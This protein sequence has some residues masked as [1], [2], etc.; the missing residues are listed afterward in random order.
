M[1]FTFLLMG[2]SA[3]VWATHGAALGEDLVYVKKD[4]RKE[5]REASIEATANFKLP[6]K[7]Q[8]LGPVELAKSSEVEPH[9]LGAA[10]PDLA[11]PAFAAPPV[12]WR[13]V[14][15]PDG[16]VHQ[17]GSL[18]P[19]KKAAVY[20]YRR[21]ETTEPRS[22]R[23]SLGYDDTMSVWLNGQL[24]LAAE[25]SRTTRTASGDMDFVTLPLTAGVNHLVM[26][27]ANQDG[28]WAFFCDVTIPTGPLVRL[29]RLLD[30]DFPPSGEA[31]YYRIETLPLPSGELI[32]VG[33]LAFRPDGAL[34]VATRRGDL[35]LVRNVEAEDVSEVQFQLFA[36]GLHESLG[37][38]AVNDHEVYVAQRPEITLVRDTNGDD[39]ADEYV[40]VSDRYNISGA[41]HEFVYGA[42]RN[43]AGDLFAGLNLSLSGDEPNVAYRGCILKIGQDGATAPI[44]FG[45]RSPNG[46][47]I[48]PQGKLFVT[49]NQGEWIP[50]CKMAAIDEGKFYGHKKSIRWVPGKKDDDEVEVA[51]PA[52]WFPYGLCRSATEPIWDTTAGK[53]GPFAG[54][55]FVGELT[56]SLILRTMLEEVNGQTQGACVAF[57]KGFASG[58]NR[59]A[60]APG[61]AMIVGQTNRGW[62]SVGGQIQALQRV[63][64]TGRTP[65][66]ISA[67]NVTPTGWKVR[68]TLPC[69]KE[70]AATL[71]NYFLES[72]KY[73]YWVR[74]GS[75]EIE[76]RSQPVEAVKVSD[77]GYEIELT[78][79]E[80]EAGRVY[81]L[82]ID[83]VASERGDALLHRDAYY[84]LN[85]I[86][87]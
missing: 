30:R 48:S 82:K 54:D 44:A 47:G 12:Q 60:M 14:N 75:P 56:N 62:G 8:M 29:E 83:G 77:D 71:E 36:R 74:Y 18:K 57:R 42:V 69:G 61:G 40:T 22:V 1:H 10:G 72:Y 79:G 76:K 23:L 3:A 65:F 85:A 24:L 7:W 68:F 31:A 81:R 25:G 58:V 39:E 13:E 41:Y 70:A 28:P 63:L 64:F 5:A 43:P 51:P 37:L 20:L 84:T 45:F 33:G 52:I 59:L 9:V 35:W 53:F 80:R 11:N 55:C 2:L 34:W 27:V 73:H 32:E 17:I 46:M 67:M 49:D 19:N 50:A 86:P 78:V 38:W 16:R 4:S 6:G 26:R 87:Q 15:Y 21:M 66:E